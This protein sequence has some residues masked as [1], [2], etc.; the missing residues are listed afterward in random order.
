MEEV[1][2]VSCVVTVTEGVSCL[3]SVT[4]PSAATAWSTT[5]LFLARSAAIAALTSITVPSADVIVPSGVSGIMFTL[6][7]DFLRLR[8]AWMAA[9]ISEIWECLPAA[10]ASLS[11]S[12]M[13]SFTT[14]TISLA[15]TSPI[16]RWST[17]S[18][19]ACLATTTFATV[20]PQSLSLIESSPAL[21]IIDLTSSRA[22]AH[23][24]TSASVHPSAT[25]ESTVAGSMCRLFISSCA[26]FFTSSLFRFARRLEPASAAAA[27]RSSSA[28]AS[29]LIASRGPMLGPLGFFFPPAGIAPDAEMQ[30]AERGQKPRSR[31]RRPI[32]LREVTC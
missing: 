6:V 10:I 29:L 8:S 13:D 15:S 32:K 7:P 27:A 23:S 17:V 26:H 4:F 3:V 11:T 16:T 30:Q 18:M 21:P 24:V 12:T 1:E 19:R 5:F 9:L 14:I 20:M 28:S 25:R 2:G 22:A 31:R